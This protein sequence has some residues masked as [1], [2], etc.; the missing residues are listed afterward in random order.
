MAGRVGEL[1]V[2]ALVDYDAHGRVTLDLPAEHL[3]I[4]RDRLLQVDGRDL[5][6]IEC[7]F[8]HAPSPILYSCNAACELIPTHTLA[9]IGTPALEEP[10]TFSGEPL[11]GL[12]VGD[13]IGQ[14]AV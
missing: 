3:L 5:N 2:R 9:W 7:C 11:A 14:Y 12:V 8:G 10:H 1:R 6:V 4:E 13:R